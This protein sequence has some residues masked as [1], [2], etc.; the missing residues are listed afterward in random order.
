MQWIQALFGIK[1]P[2]VAMCHLHA[3]P[4]DPAYAA[5]RGMAWVIEQARQ[6]IGRAHV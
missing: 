6:E 1:K 3:L 4:G 5:E 2:I